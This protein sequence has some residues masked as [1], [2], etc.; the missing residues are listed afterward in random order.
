MTTRRILFLCTGN[1]YRSRYADILFNHHAESRGSPWR[2]FS[3]GLA[4]ERGVNN[5][6]PMSRAAR[7]RLEARGVRTHEFER[8]PAGLTT[9]DLE[10]AARIVALKEVEHRPLMLERFPGWI[11][12][13]EF[14]HVDD[15]DVGPVDEALSLIDRTLETLFTQL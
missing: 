15:V 8:L 1:Y 12:R 14:W 3:R 7:A 11:D 6:G 9:A 13:T 4:V 2:A 5:V 10:Q